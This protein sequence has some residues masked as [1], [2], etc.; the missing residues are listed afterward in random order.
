MEGGRRE[1]ER[2]EG[3]GGG[4]EKRHRKGSRKEGGRT[5]RR[6]RNGSKEKTIL[7]LF[8]PRQQPLVG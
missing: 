8:H 3:R 6:K 5:Q 7:T 4:I 1:G 2:N